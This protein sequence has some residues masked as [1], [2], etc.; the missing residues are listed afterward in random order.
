M[1][2]KFSLEKVLRHRIILMD[3]AKKSF[4]EAQAVQ[5]AE[6][7]KLVEMLELKNSTLENR[8]QQI[9]SSQSWTN[10]VEQ[11]NTFLHG[12]DL[13]IKQQNLRLLDFE[14]V[15]EA[16]REILRL[17]LIEVKIMEKLKEKKKT[18][19]L[20][21]AMKKEQAELDELSVLRFSRIEN[22][23]KGSHEDGI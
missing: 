7:K 4:L 12:H 16:R 3:L 6:E 10:S 9:Q 15:V 18:E 1:K 23:L 14:K 19:F 2:F 13:R 8:T 20:T 21:E 5:V 17:A 22:P 11:I